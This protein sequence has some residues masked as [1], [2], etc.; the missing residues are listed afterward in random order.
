[1][2]SARARVAADMVSTLSSG[3]G[4][5]WFTDLEGRPAVMGRPEVVGRPAARGGDPGPRSL[6]AWKAA[7][8]GWFIW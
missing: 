6:T 4:L 2:V 3:L 5:G 1:M 7:G 8:A